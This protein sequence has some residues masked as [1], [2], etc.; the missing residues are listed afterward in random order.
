MAAAVARVMLLQT[1]RGVWHLAFEASLSAC[2][3]AGAAGA[4]A[5]AG[6]AA[7]QVARVAREMLLASTTRGVAA[8][9]GARAATGRG[10]AAAQAGMLAWAR[11]QAWSTSSEG[12]GRF[13]WVT[14]V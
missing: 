5:A 14:I 12:E 1:A 11:V 8:G 2:L 4:G 10:A 3:F 7:A 6:V 13:H 9:T